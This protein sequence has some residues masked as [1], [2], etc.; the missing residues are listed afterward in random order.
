TS[1][2]CGYPPDGSS[3]SA[4]KGTCCVKIGSGYQFDCRP[5]GD[6]CADAA[7]SFSCDDSVQCGA[8]SCCYTETGMLVD[9][10]GN[11]RA[12][13]KCG[14]CSPFDMM[15]SGTQGNCEQGLNCQP[16]FSNYWV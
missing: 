9:G 4:C 14:S 16:W 12:E 5:L 13:S 7:Y 2:W 8:Q 3:Q 11:Y 10:G 1:V 15:C 6:P